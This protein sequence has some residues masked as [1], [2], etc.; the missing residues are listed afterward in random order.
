MGFIQ[1][2]TENSNAVKGLL[3]DLIKRNFKYTQRILTLLDGS[4]GL[5]KAVDE[6]F[7][8]YALVQRCYR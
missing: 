5:R 8:K 1:T 3:K 2:T 7:G 6:T 4:K